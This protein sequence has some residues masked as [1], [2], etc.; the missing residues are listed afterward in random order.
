MPNGTSN[1]FAGMT[2][3]RVNVNKQ[4]AEPVAY[5]CPAGCGCTWRDNKDGSMSLFGHN[6][7]SCATCEHLPLSG[8]I[9]VYYPPPPHNMTLQQAEPVAWMD[10]F[11]N[12]FPLA[13]NKGAGHWLDDHKRNWKPL[14]TSTPPRI[15][16]E[17]VE[18]IK[19]LADEY[20]FRN[21]SPKETGVEW[22]ADKARSALHA[23][24]DA[25]VAKE[26]P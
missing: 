4:Q 8:L 26:T 1:M 15:T 20:A 3:K 7:R 22:P 11:G 13:A 16:A 17:Q 12:V 25:L 21:R 14:Y 10:D 9:P 23:A 2:G 5:L 24:L 6:S 18:Q 19:R